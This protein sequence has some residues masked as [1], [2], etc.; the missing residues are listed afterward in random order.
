[1][2]F[3][4]VLLSVLGGGF[5]LAGLMIVVLGIRRD[6]EE[7][8]RLFVPRPRKSWRTRTYPP[9]ASPRSYPSIGGPV[10]VGNPLRQIAEY[11]SK[12]DAAAHNN[13]IAIQ[14][15]FDAD[16]KDAA[17]LLRKEAADADDELR[18]SLR[19]VLAGSVRGRAWGAVF[20]FVGIVLAVAGSIVGT[21]SG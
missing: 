3:V 15:A 20:L 10:T 4:A 12:V 2:T 6:R 18:E 1:V 19:Y 16:L 8:R 9:K 11:V 7:A 21:L 13:F 5:E 17:D 14:K